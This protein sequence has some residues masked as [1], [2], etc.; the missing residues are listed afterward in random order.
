MPKLFLHDLAKGLLRRWYLVLFGILVT[1]FGGY[2]IFQIVP[3]NY[4]ATSSIVLV[5]PATAVIEGENPYLYMGGLDQA[6]SVLTVRM[7][8]P[9]V[10]DPILKDQPGL[11][12]SIGKDVTTTGP[13]ML[14]GAEGPTEAQTLQVLDEV[15]KVVPE[16]L[17]ILQE[18]LGIPE[19]ARITTMTIVTDTKA[20]EV[21][22]KQMRAFL[23][24]V[25]LGLGTTVL[26]TGLL[27][28]LIMGRKAKRLPDNTQS[29]RNRGRNA[30][31]PGSRAEAQKDSR[32]DVELP[33]VVP[34]SSAEESP[35]LVSTVLPHS[36]ALV[37]PSLGSVEYP[38]PETVGR[39]DEDTVGGIQAE[40]GNWK[41]GRQTRRGRNPDAVES[42]ETEGSTAGVEVEDHG[43]LSMKS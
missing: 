34:G 12:F 11:N 41:R 27:D 35:V 37:E 19:N 36:D 15:I 32:A 4:E 25:A 1:G 9:L 42:V 5:P 40:S 29:H 14:V 22:K 26:A 2:M 13:I 18:Q 8:A 17:A 21:T 20:K 39:P 23:G 28:R 30:R 43:S 38:E 33:G 6:L 16:N 3:V 7:S 24:V 31:N 10:A